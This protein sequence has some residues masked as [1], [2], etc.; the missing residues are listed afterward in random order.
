MTWADRFLSN[1]LI[2]G[3]QISHRLQAMTGRV[4]LERIWRQ[5]KLGSQSR[6]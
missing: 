3:S 5:S 4:A 2:A 1:L 6:Q